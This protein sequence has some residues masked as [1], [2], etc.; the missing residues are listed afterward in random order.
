M[1]KLPVSECA[2]GFVEDFER[3]IHAF[4]HKKST[5]W[6][7]F[8]A[9]LIEQKFDCLFDFRLNDRECRE[10]ILH[11]MFRKVCFCFLVFL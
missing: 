9:T 7:V 3:L 8:E 5:L 10:V 6:S 11:Y 1:S 2:Q 4:C